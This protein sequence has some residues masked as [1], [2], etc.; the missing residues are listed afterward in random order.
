MLDQSLLQSHFIGRDGFRWWI[1]QIPPIGS[2]GEQVEGGGWG[3]RFKVRILGY[4][5]Y[6]EAELPNEDLPWAQCLIPTTAGSGAANVS[7]GIQ[8]QQGDVVLGFFL[9]GDNAQ[10]PVI[11]ATFGRSDSVPSADYQ[12]PF[13]PF[14]GFSS[15]MQKNKVTPSESNEVKTNSLPSPQDVSPEQAK[16]LSPI[17]G[18]QVVST[19][20]AI[21][22][23]VPLANTVQNTKTS[24]IKSII[25]NL[26]KK[27]KKIQGDIQR[28]RNEIRKAAQKIVALC[29]EF[30]GL[31][32]KKLINTLKSL[33]KKG[34]DLLY[35][36]V[37]NTVLAATGNPAAAHLAGVAAQKAMVGPVKALENAFSCVAGE[38]INKLVGVVTDIITSVVDNVDRFVSC[39]ADQFVGSLLNTI[40]DTLEFLMS[41]PLA[42]VEKLLQ[43]FSDFSV[44][45]LMRS[46][47]DGLASAG[48]AFDC[49]QNFDKF[50]GLVNEWVVGGGPK[51]GNANPYESIKNIVNIQNSGIDPNKVLECFSGALQFANPPTINIFGGTGSGCSAIPIFGN[52]ITREDGAVTASVIGVQITNPGS[53]YTFPPFVEI[54]DDNDQ[55]YGAIARSIINENGE[56]ESIYIVS[57]GENYSVGEIGNYSVID[58]IVEEGGSGYVDGDIVVDNLG[59]EYI[60]EVVDGRIYKVT[61]LNNVVQTIPILIADPRASKESNNNLGGSGAILRPLLGSPKFTGEVKTIVDCITK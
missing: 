41:G 36:L 23:I 57:E 45:G 27:L 58:V 11:L 29:N 47:I 30:V 33:L 37:Y 40:I 8:L 31:L 49:N 7:T 26:L 28:I 20:S 24:K 54:V 2:M 16:Q 21:G 15:L 1:G 17:F 10:I 50:K 61:P 3:N 53:G 18:Y 46:V 39:A 34:L 6:S 55:G 14:T 13:T 38:V 32:M 19:N 4:H 9:D 22:D 59:N 43:F 44:G 51:Y 60:T 48:A 42:G 5:P 52:L 25:T 35:K 12:S 56:V